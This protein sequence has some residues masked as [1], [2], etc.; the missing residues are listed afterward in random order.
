[1]KP[2]AVII[3]LLVF[4]LIVTLISNATSIVIAVGCCCVPAYLTFTVIESQEWDAIKKY[5]V[6]WIIYAILEV[7][8][9]ILAFIMPAT[10]YV[11]VRIGIAVAI[12]HPE[13]SIG[14]KIYDDLIGPF[15]EKHER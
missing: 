13:S 7:I 14:L 10:L 5:L 4:L 12:I 3:A 15:L 8:G 11:I 9:P 1:M 6:Y 2:S